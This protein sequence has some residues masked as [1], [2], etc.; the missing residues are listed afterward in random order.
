MVGRG[1][2]AVGCA[3]CKVIGARGACRVCMRLVCPPCEADWTTCD[4]PSGR[5]VRLGRTARLRDVDP[6]GRL[7]LVSRW[8]GP[9]R[10]LDLRRL[11]WVPSE[12]TRK[13]WLF[14]G[15]CAP[16]L[17]S[18]GRVLY[19]W[20]DVGPGESLEIDAAL[21]FVGIVRAGVEGGDAPIIKGPAP[22]QGSGVSK[23]G[24]VFWYTADTQ[25]VVTM[26][27]GPTPERSDEVTVATLDPL[28]YKVVQAAYVDGA[29][30]LLA[31]GTWGQIVLHRIVDGRLE[32]LGA[33]QTSGDLRWIEVAGPYLAAGVSRGRRTNVHVWRLH[34]DRTIGEEV[35]RIE[36]HRALRAASLARD[37]RYLAVAF[38]DD[39]QVIAVDRGTTVTFGEHTDGVALVRFVGDDHLLVTADHDNR[40]VL[41]P[42]TEDG[43]A[44]AVIPLEL[45]DGEV[46]LPAS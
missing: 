23:V 9:L 36:G 35:H 19:A 11:R 10:M 31:S 26:T 15:R 45:D 20:F 4:E 25:I 37:G 29:R 22:L 40:V 21:R 27:P 38:G 3:H 43:Y 13:A 8:R 28:P 6:S 18:S 30:G 5:V 42:R 2:G 41:R 17:T 7:G 39:V 46:E 34:E 12:V 1:P 16:R 24:D 44:A 14:R 33:A 32:R